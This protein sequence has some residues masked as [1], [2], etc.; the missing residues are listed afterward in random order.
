MGDLLW[1][2][3]YTRLKQ[4]LNKEQKV[5]EPFVFFE[6]K[7]F[8]LDGIISKKKNTLL[9]FYNTKYRRVDEDEQ[10]AN[11]CGVE[12]GFF[13]RMREDVLPLFLKESKLNV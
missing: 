8:S 7:N 6:K 11:V 10:M 3:H 2:L 1:N 5:L 4:C 9:C 12:V 13:K